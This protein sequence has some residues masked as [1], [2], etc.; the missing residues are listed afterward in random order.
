MLRLMAQAH[1]YTMLCRVV[2]LAPENETFRKAV[3]AL[4]VPYHGL[5]DLDLWRWYRLIR[6]VRPDVLYVFGRFRTVAWIALARLAGVR[7]VVA[8]ERSAANRRSD[9]LARTLDRGLVDAY[10]ANTAC[11]AD[12]LRRIVGS[13]GPP[14][15]VVVNGIPGVPPAPASARDP[16]VLCI[17]NITPNKGQ[18]VLLEAVR[19]LQGRFPGVRAVLVGRDHTRGAFF[20]EA[21][22]AGLAPFFRVEGF[23]EDICPYLAGAT[24]LALPT[25]RRE[26]MPTSVLESMAAGVPVVASRV[27]GVGEIVRGGET[28]LLVEPGDVAQLADAIGLLLGDPEMR[29]RLASNARRYVLRYHDVGTMV[30]GH[31]R[32][33]R[34]AMARAEG[35]TPRSAPGPATVA[36]VTTAAIS[37]RYLLLNQL[38]VIR[39]RGYAVTGIS[40]RGPD[41]EALLSEGLPHAPVE[42]TRRVTPLADL[43]SLVRL[44]RLMRDRAFTIVHT[45]NP[46]PGLLG[47]LAARLAGVPIVVNTLHGF[48]FHD[49][50]PWMA[51]RFYVGVERLAARCSD[52]ILSQNGEDIE[53]A[54]REG[55]APRARLRYLG[56]GIDLS[57]FDPGRLAP[58][59]R[60][61][62]RAGLGIPED[63]LVVGFVGRLVAE[64]GVSDLLRAAPRVLAAVPEAR[65]LFV[66][67]TDAEKGDRVTP[68]AAQDLR[69]ACI[70][71][72]VR[73]DMPELY[74]SMDV[75]V[76]PSHREGFPRAPME[77]SA[78]RVPCVVT[79][80]RGCRETVAEGRNGVLVPVRDAE[81][82]ARAILR[83]LADP[84]LAARFGE[85]GR[86]RAVREFDERRVFERVLDAY[87][88]L[89]VSRGLRGRIAPR[90]AL[91]VGG[92]E[93]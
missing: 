32:A 92:A 19:R 64:K 60:Q 18:H 68:E 36:H 30:D 26:G 87:E 76:L 40:S 24:L 10:I 2:V 23:V 21:N 56:N 38:L 33:F 41:V 3:G 59:A 50:M 72:G 22:R 35:R 27:G 71:A 89:L 7:C 73:E 80:I 15:S 17:G 9:H 82:L 85:E 70:F 29:R 63:A 65:F 28:G 58:D 61:R 34:E 48:Y 74:R 77:A 49:K 12:N 13:G 62:T 81:A 4:G 44:S 45:H 54:V 42:M 78:M 16:V 83:L 43:L 75:F 51:R 67:G 53:T 37:L 69:G 11:A 39:D 91:A 14:V 86:R 6:S 25:L 66:G 52:L 46:K 55:I 31:R 93:G 79:D 88:E 90:R 8:A 57:R 47:Q 84:A 20:H 5:S 1:P